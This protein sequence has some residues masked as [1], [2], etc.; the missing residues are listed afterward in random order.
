MKKDTLNFMFN[1]LLEL[2]KE[3]VKTAT[4][5]TVEDF[6]YGQAEKVTRYENGTAAVTYKGIEYRP[7]TE[8]WGPLDGNKNKRTILI[9]AKQ[10]PAEPDNWTKVEF[11][12]N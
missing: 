12:I 10:N 11:K 5:A 8:T 1:M 7:T 2:E 6:K 4:G 3:R 9:N